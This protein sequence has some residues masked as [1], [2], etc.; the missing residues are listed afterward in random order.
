CGTFR[1]KDRRGWCCWLPSPITSL[2]CADQMC[3]VALRRSGHKQPREVAFDTPVTLGDRRACSAN[4]CR[5]RCCSI[6]REHKGMADAVSE[7]AS[8]ESDNGKRMA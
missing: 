7:V 6:A 3:P 8:G 1:D 5:V 2:A 4:R